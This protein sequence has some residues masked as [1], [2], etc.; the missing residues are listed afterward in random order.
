MLKFSGTESQKTPNLDLGGT[1]TR[2]AEMEYPLDN[3]GANLQNM[4]KMVEEMEN[5]MRNTI[6]EIYFAKT[7][8]IIN[9]LRS[10]Q[11]LGEV[12][13]RMQMQEALINGL[14]GKK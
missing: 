3:F 9:D 11:D 8:D 2:Q 1:V 4:G 12:K 7:R 5:K 13:K 14:K 6:Q 10:M